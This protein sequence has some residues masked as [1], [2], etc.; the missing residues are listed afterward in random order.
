MLAEA[1][2]VSVAVDAM[3]SGATD[4]LSRPVASE[5]LVEAL[6]ANAD[7]RRPGGELIPVSEKLA[8]PLSLEQ[9][10]GAAPDFRASLAVAAKAAR[11]RLPILIWAGGALLGYIAGEVIVTDPAI[12]HEVAEVPYL[13][14]A[15][16]IAGAVLTVLIALAIMRLKAQRERKKLDL[17]S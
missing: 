16:P 11:N 10:V 12:H 8:P 13:H 5:R 6:A 15:A 9:L 2:S 3:R 4:F 7:R 1:T 14:S 17:I